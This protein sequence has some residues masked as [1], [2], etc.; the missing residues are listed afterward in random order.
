MEEFAPKAV[1]HWRDLSADEV[2]Y[3]AHLEN[4]ARDA[5]ATKLASIAFSNNPTGQHAEAKSIFT[6]HEARAQSWFKDQSSI[7]GMLPETAELSDFSV[8]LQV[9]FEQRP[10]VFA[11]DIAKLAGFSPGYLSA[12]RNGKKQNPSEDVIDRIKQAFKAA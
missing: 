2:Y 10:D 11:K 1:L 6:N 3:I 7:R 12:L 9:Q 8:W 4:E 5:M